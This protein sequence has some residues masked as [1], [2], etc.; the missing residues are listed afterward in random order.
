MQAVILVAGLGTR[1]KSRI[2]NIPKDM[3]EFFNIL[4]KYM[5]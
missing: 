1:F 3:M 5:V 2:K 4:K